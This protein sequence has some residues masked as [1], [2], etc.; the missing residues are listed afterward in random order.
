MELSRVKAVHHVR[1]RKCPLYPC[2]GQ[3]HD[4]GRS[5]DPIGMRNEFAALRHHQFMQG[6]LRRAI[7]HPA[8]LFDGQLAKCLACRRIVGKGTAVGHDRG[9]D[10]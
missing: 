9:D 4:L 3:A 5:R 7:G 2:G 1:I 8:E 6:L 10:Q